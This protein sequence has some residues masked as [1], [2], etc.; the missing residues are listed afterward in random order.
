MEIQVTPEE[1]QNWYD[2]PITKYLF[3]EL[4]DTKEGLKD[5]VAEGN[6]LM[7]NST[8]EFI[9]QIK[10]LNQAFIV[11]SD[12]REEMKDGNS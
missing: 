7:N 2:N 10:G 4:N 5:Y 6:T 1:L 11:M 3:D 9:G 8:A 12:V